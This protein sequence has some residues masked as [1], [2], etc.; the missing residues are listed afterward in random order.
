[1]LAGIVLAVGLR[2]EQSML[3][4]SVLLEMV[5]LIGAISFF[6][7]KELPLR[8][9]LLYISLTLVTLAAASLAMAALWH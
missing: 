2:V 7:H 4:V 5:G 3:I 6:G 1:V 9:R 8:V